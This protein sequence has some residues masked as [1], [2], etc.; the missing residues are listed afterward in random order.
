MPNARSIA[1]YD[2]VKAV[3]D[4]ALAHGLPVHYEL[5]SP[6]AAIRWRSRASSFRKLSSASDYKPL[7]FSIN[8][9]TPQ[10]V[11]ILTNEVGVLKSPDGMELEIAAAT[12]TLS[13]ADRIAQELA[14]ELGI[15]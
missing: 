2:D 7:V 5:S 4:S 14:A 1:A 9:A 15:K 12:P 3:L 11:T 13:D 10:T 6:A 8:K